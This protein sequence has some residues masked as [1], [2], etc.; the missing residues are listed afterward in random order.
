[1]LPRLDASGVILFA[2]F[3]AE[4]RSRCEAPRSA[5]PARR[6][7][8]QDVGE[9]GG[10]TGGEPLCSLAALWVGK[11]AAPG[12]VSRCGSSM[13]RLY[14]QHGVD[15]LGKTLRWVVPGSRLLLTHRAAML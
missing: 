3:C 14:P 11:Q 7:L 10:T 9:V 13:G 12:N 15:A 5:S 6:A 8:H 2:D 1:M 4:D